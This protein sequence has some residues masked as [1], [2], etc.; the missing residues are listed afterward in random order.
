[1][2][3]LQLGTMNEVEVREWVE[4][5]PKRVNDRDSTSYTPLMVAVSFIKSL[6]LTVLTRRAQTPMRDAIKG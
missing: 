5:N 6:S 3:A 4:A 2:A 1:M